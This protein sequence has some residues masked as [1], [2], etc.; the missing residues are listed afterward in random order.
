VVSRAFDVIVVGGG[1]AGSVCAT[2]L[3][4]AGARVTLIERQVRPGEKV[5]G[6]YVSPR[7]VELLREHGLDDV[8]RRRPHREL[9]GMLLVSPSGIEVPT[10]FP[11]DRAAGLSIARAELDAAPT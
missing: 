9:H 5:C 2:L 6:E 4:R 7:G 10:R 11:A 1:P 3:A 8:V